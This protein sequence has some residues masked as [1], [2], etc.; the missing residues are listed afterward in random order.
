MLAAVSVGQI[1]AHIVPLW[2]KIELFWPYMQF[3][4]PSK[5][6]IWPKLILF[7]VSLKFI[8]F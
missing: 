6:V 2:V 1:S 5:E 3:A 8:P 4:D 7:D